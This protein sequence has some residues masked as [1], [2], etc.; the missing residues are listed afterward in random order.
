MAPVLTRLQQG[1]RRK[2]LFTSYTT[3]KAALWSQLGS[4]FPV[5]FFRVRLVE[6]GSPHSLP[7]TESGKVM[8]AEPS[9]LF[10]LVVHHRGNIE[11]QGRKGFL[12]QGAEEMGD[13]SPLLKTYKHL[14]VF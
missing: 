8:G 13:M 6:R 9:L 5:F 1:V 3:L 4:R 12:G 10:L 11:S 7:L 14:L 2:Q